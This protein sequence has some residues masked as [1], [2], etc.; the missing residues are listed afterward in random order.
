MDQ[1][2]IIYPSAKGKKKNSTG[3]ISC[4][5]SFLNTVKKLGIVL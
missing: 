3:M 2:I 1:S 4:Y 5:E